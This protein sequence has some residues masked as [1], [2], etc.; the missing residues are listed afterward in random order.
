MTVNGFS[1]REFANFNNAENQFTL[2]MIVDYPGGDIYRLNDT[3]YSYFDIVFSDEFSYSSAF[4]N[5]V[6]NA[7]GVSGKGLNTGGSRFSGFAN[8]AGGTGSPANAQAVYQQHA[9]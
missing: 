1:P 5:Q 7:I 3:V 9:I 8:P 6:E 2:Q 4:V